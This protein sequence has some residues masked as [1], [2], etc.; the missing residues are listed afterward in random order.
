MPGYLHLVPP[1]QKPFPTPVYQ[2][3]A[4]SQLPQSW[5]DKRPS[6]QG[7]CPSVSDVTRQGRNRGPAEDEDDDEDENDQDGQGA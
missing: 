4:R 2:I 6:D 5:K 7:P 3:D 1:G